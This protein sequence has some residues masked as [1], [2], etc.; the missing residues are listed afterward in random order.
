MT[1]AMCEMPVPTADPC[2]IICSGSAFDSHPVSTKDALRTHR[3]SVPTYSE[4]AGR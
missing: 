4:N 1:H 2:A 3:H